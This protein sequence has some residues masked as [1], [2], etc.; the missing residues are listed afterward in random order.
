VLLLADDGVL[1]TF[2]LKAGAMNFGGISGE[3]RR[4]VDILPTGNVAVGRDM[5]EDERLIINDAFLIT[6]FQI[7]VETPAMT[8]TEVLERAR[9]KAALLAPIAGRQESEDLGPSIDREVDL[10]MQQRRLPEFTPAMQEAGAQFRVEYD[11]PMTR[12]QKAEAAGGGIRMYQIAAE[13]AA[14]TQDPSAFD[15]FDPDTMVP[16]LA[17]AQAMP[18]SW[19]RDPAEVA[20]IREGRQQQA[21]TQQMIEAAPSMAAMMKATTGQQ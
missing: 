3:G 2:S 1:D 12:M 16:E 19:M 17:E 13:I 5:M 15:W 4:M 20:K 14:Q 8:A 11:S 9:E 10:L 18:A 6:L 7:L 21:A